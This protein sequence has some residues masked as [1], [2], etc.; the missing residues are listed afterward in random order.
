MN[1]TFLPNLNVATHWLTISVWW[2][3]IISV[4]A[5]PA[6]QTQPSSLQIVQDDQATLRVTASGNGPLQYQWYK[7]LS[8]DTSAPIIGAVSPEYTTPI[9][10]KTT[11]YWVKIS[12]AEGSTLSDTALVT[13]ISPKEMIQSGLA[14]L[15]ANQLDN[16]SWENHAATTAQVLLALLNGG[17]REDA[18]GANPAGPVSRGL[19]YL[20]SQFQSVTV[21]VDGNQ[22]PALFLGGS[23]ATYHI[24]MAIMTLVA[25]R[26]PAYYDEIK[27]LRNY[28]LYAQSRGDSSYDGA[29][30]YNIG[31]PYSGDMSNSQWGYFAIRAAENTLKDGFAEEVF[32]R[33]VTFL[34]ACQG[35]DGRGFYLPSYSTSHDR[36][37]T[38]ALV[39]SLALAGFGPEDPRVQKGIAW[40]TD[41]YSWDYG[42]ARYYNVLTF[43]KALVMSHK[44]KL[45]DKNWYV[46]MC[47]HLL[48]WRDTDGSWY[49]GFWLDH[50]R[51]MN[52]A[53]AV[54][55][56]QTRALPE[57]INPAA[58]ITLRS[59]ADLH[60]YD[61]E[62]RH[63]G[64][65]YENNTLNNEIPNAVFLLKQKDENGL[66]TGDP[67][68]WPADGVISEEWA[69]IIQIPLSEAGTYRIELVG[70]SDG[71][72]DL[73]V[74]GLEDYRVVTSETTSGS[75]AKGMVL[76]T[77]V[78][79]TSLEGAITLLYEPIRSLP[80]LMVE[81]SLLIIDPHLTTAQTF[82]LKIK[83][84][85]GSSDL[86]GVNIFANTVGALSGAVVTF[87]KNNFRVPKGS[88]TE[89]QVTIALPQ[90][91]SLPVESG[92]VRV[93]TAG[94]GSRTIKVSPPP[95]FMLDSEMASLPGTGGTVK[96][97]VT[98]IT[99]T[100][101][102][103]KVIFNDPADQSWIT[104][105][106]GASGIGNGTVHLSIAAGPADSATVSIA[107]LPFTVNRESGASSGF[108]VSPAALTF[109]KEGGSAQLMI[110]SVP[111]SS[112][113]WV[114]YSSA[115]WLGFPSGR[116]GVGSGVLS[117]VVD[118]LLRTG[119]ARTTTL[120]VAGQEVSIL[121][122]GVQTLDEYFG[123]V[124][125]DKGNDQ[126]YVDGFGAFFN[127][128]GSFWVW[129]EEFGWI[130]LD[131][132]GLGAYFIWDP[133]L[134]WIFTSHISFYPFFYRFR[135]GNWY[136]I[137]TDASE[138]GQRYFYRYNGLVWESYR[139]IP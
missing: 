44:T 58:W 109:G 70:T 99:V 103:W 5:S 127:V 115:S 80:I 96:V 41:N 114:A 51:L 64:K 68:P 50:T 94:G 93:E 71:Q 97:E 39:W 3:S 112:A 29:F 1:T 14:Y 18:P 37:M 30:S 87:D 106:S 111:P 76:S 46:D 7:G 32:Q 72:F 19:A 123:P 66:P 126:Y 113:T 48:Q 102:E 119:A 9:L 131:G 86:E 116:T 122:A 36:C 129:H 125:Q 53:W 10:K 28:L 101:A 121:Q 31:G 108:T 67:L 54:L 43:S 133:E 82:T 107:G 61:P 21:T 16:G 2:L 8:G 78:T 77:N 52:T 105:T 124:L 17:Y 23:D 110:T 89:L 60:V 135:D 83:E 4:W 117:I 49:S 92:S 59:H 38:S 104:I 98:A 40:L 100:D 118:P 6:I 27:L 11:T 47:R 22:L 132:P 24:S 13:V 75:I 95:A 91:L 90:A 138:P 139:Y 55:S 81:P 35:V 74:E 65:N 136:V 42:N 84:T 34:E 69:Q 85:S 63:I 120:L 20:T 45:G 134:D 57:N 79:V 88:E 15:L 128:A 62:G 33:A 26:N 130:Y 73:T 25:T 12:D 56:M 137:N